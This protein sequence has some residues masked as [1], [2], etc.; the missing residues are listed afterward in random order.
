MKI[1]FLD[2]D[3][4]LTGKETT[5]LHFRR[6]PYNGKTFY[7]LDT[8]NIA[9]LNRITRATGAKIVVSST[10]RKGRSMLE[11]RYI[12]S[13]HH[14]VEAE[15]ID[16]TPVLW[17]YRGHEIQAW[18]DENA[19]RERVERFVI[20]DDDSDME[21]LMPFLVKTSTHIGLTDKDV[22][23]AIALLAEP[24]PPLAQ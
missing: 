21:H 22:E 18:L 9:R 24:L 13:V 3:G 1:I 4:V 2:I 19:V 16:A 14:G 17:K 8:E 12:L 11:L 6:I 15:I 23:R 7:Q 5:D 20:L 10:W